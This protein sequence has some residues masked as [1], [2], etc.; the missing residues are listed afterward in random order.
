MPWHDLFLKLLLLQLFMV[1]LALQ[2]AL[3]FLQFRQKT[4]LLLDQL[5]LASDAAGAFD[6]QGIVLKKER[7]SVPLQ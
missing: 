4:Q 3:A 7:E 1:P 5:D 6:A 2:L